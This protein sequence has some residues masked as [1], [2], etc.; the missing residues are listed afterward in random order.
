VTAQVELNKVLLNLKKIPD[1]DRQ[2]IHFATHA[3]GN[4]LT[5]TDGAC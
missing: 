4:F 5:A 2:D 3:P 1:P